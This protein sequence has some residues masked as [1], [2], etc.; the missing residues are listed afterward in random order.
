MKKFTYNF[1]SEST[2]FVYL[3][4]LFLISVNLVKP[5]RQTWSQT[6]AR[7]YSNSAKKPVYI[8]TPIFYVNAGTKKKKTSHQK[9]TKVLN[10]F[11]TFYIFI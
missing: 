4:P 2:D 3:F 8:T 5:W 7:L 11:N 9:E 1:F 6:Q 10:Y